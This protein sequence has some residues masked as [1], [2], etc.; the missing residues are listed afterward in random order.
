MNVNMEKLS[1]NISIA[2]VKKPLLLEFLTCVRATDFGFLTKGKLHA[3]LT[4][5][6][7]EA[8]EESAGGTN[9]SLFSGEQMNANFTDRIFQRLFLAEK[10]TDLFR[11]L[12]MHV[13]MY[14]YLSI[15]WIWYDVKRVTFQSFVSPFPCMLNLC[16][17][18]K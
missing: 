11:L 15:P 12:L 3:V 14:W 2:I 10:S 4:I 8:L 18:Y 1:N 17:H 5:Y 7:H 6:S 13:N 16:L 9:N